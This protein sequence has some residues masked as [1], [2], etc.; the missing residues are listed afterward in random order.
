MLQLSFLATRQLD[1]LYCSGVPVSSLEGDCS[2][3][4]QQGNLE[5]L[6]SSQR[7]LREQAVKQSQR[8][9]ELNTALRSKEK[10]VKQLSEENLDLVRDGSE[11][12]GLAN[13]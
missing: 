8:I 9:N 12:C 5:E 3:V 1:L 13:Q 7:P 11:R 10:Q 2:L 4:M 6:E